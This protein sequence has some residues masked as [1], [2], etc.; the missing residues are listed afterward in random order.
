[1]DTPGVVCRPIADLAGTEHFGEIFFEGV[2]VPADRLIGEVDRGWEVA[3]YA[4]Q[5]ERGM[6]GWIRQA[7]ML[8]LLRELA[9]RLP[10]GSRPAFGA[11]YQDVAAL[12]LRSLATIEALNAGRSSGPQVSIDKLLLS[13]AERSVQDLLD[14]VRPVA[15]DDRAE[16]WETRLYD[17]LHSRSAPI[18]GGSEEIQRGIVAS[19]ILELRGRR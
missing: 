17:Y 4:L 2:R 1:M 8:V 16:D 14:A 10:E 3:Q 12:R 11:A 13:T 9:D 5:W 18:Y 19:Q 15:I 6:F 7:A